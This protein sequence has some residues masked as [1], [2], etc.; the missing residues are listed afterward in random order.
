M[1][2]FFA[3]SIRI[4]QG[5][6]R[7]TFGPIWRIPLEGFLQPSRAGVAG[8]NVQDH[9]V[10][11]LTFTIE[12]DAQSVPL[13]VFLKAIE[14]VHRLVRHVDYAVTREKQGRPWIVERLQSSS[15]TITIRPLIDGMGTVET[16]VGGLQ[17]IADGYPTVPPPHFTEEA[18]DALQRMQGLFSGSERARALVFRTNGL[19]VA[20]I[21]SDIK[22]KVEPILRGG[23]Y[24]L[25]SI[26]G[27]LEEI[28]L[29]RNPSFTIWDR[30]G[31][32]PIKC[33]FSRT[34]EWIEHVKE[35]LERDVAVDGRIHYFQNGV[36]RSISQISTLE[37]MSFDRP[38]PK[39]TFGSIPDI[40]D[41]EDS[42]EYLRSMRD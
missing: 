26:E 33:Q 40:T 29:H 34:K 9:A 41:G 22:K 39:A 5:V 38:L 17:N 3:V 24:S 16:I 27:R 28:N 42:V 23:Y 35:L 8:G 15:P 32:L 37:A 19:Q 13:S 6:C 25:G 36:P 4:N 18:L 21:R 2:S 7:W 1:H 20:T 12:P 11:S 31:G 14:D 10:E 30:L